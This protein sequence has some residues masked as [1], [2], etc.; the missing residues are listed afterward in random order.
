MVFPPIKWKLL[1]N[2]WN[3]VE[4]LKTLCDVDCCY[5]RRNW[6]K[7]QYWPQRFY[8]NYV[9][10]KN[11]SNK[12]LP[13]VKTEPRTSGS[14][15]NT[16]LDS[17]AS[18]A[19]ACKTETLGS[20]YSHALLILSPKI[21]WCINR[22][23][24]SLGV[25]FCHWNFTFSGSKASNAN[26][27]IIVKNSIVTKSYEFFAINTKLLMLASKV[28]TAA[29]SFLQW[30]LTWWSLVQESNAQPTELT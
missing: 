22:V 9:K 16:L 20:L 14:K 6:Q 27:C 23:Q 18:L 11:S 17:W 15:S 25:T 5:I 29:K 28:F 26:I 13:P 8:I 19:F 21:K 2:R 1:N 3:Q 7:Y 4:Y 30:N 12:M 24:T 10:T